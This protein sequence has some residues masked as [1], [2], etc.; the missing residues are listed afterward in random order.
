M[1]LRIALVI[2][3]TMTVSLLAAKEQQPRP[4]FRTE[5]NFVR[6]DAFPTKNG[7]PVLDLTKDDFEIIEEHA[8]QPIEQFEHVLIRAQNAQN[9]GG[10]NVRQDP[11]TVEESR[12]AVM[13]PRARVFV[14]FLDTNHVD[15]GGSWRVREPLVQALDKLIGPDDLFAV[16]TPQMSVSSLTFARKT[17]TLAG[18]L[19][20]HWNWGRQ[21][22]PME[23]TPRERDCEA[24][25]PSV[26]ALVEEAIA[27]AREQETLNA[28][29]D[30]LDYL[31]VVREER[32]A[33][34]TVTDG[35]VLYQPNP[36]L[37]S[38]AR[39][40]GADVSMLHDDRVFLDLLN[41]ANTA[42]ASFYPIDPRGLPVFDQS[43]TRPLTPGPGMQLAG[44]NNAKRPELDHADFNARRQTLQTLAG[45]TD[46]LAMINSNDLTSSFTK[47]VDD[48]SSYYLL[49]YHSTSKQDGRFHEITVR[50]K[51]PGVQV[52]ARHG[53]LAAAPHTTAAPGVAPTVPE[54]KLDAAAAAVAAAAV[55]AAVAPLN[56]YV[57][58]KPLRVQAATNGQ[59]VWVEGEGNVEINGSA[60]VTVSTTDGSLLASKYVPITEGSH[61]FMSVLTPDTP[62]SAGPY[63]IHITAGDARETMQM[64]VPP[65]PHLS[66][67]IWERRRPSNS[68]YQLAAADLR[69]RRSDLLIAKV[70]TPIGENY[71]IGTARVLDAKGNPLPIPVMPK[72]ETSD[73]FTERWF[74][75]QVVLAPLAPGD[76]IIELT[77]TNNA[78]A[79]TLAA[80]KIVP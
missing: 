38:L 61:T 19:E 26:P 21:D 73:D 32:K 78:N 54:P 59:K 29:G 39:G 47:I 51:R 20:R 2:S 41:A 31:R 68:R 49:G 44:F 75:A 71:R 58:E 24:A 42:N 66:G 79:R 27:R 77:D 55:A 80:F 36:A 64:V 3:V 17:T 12:D 53:Y 46:G 70:P 60:A 67:M 43:I 30:L 22:N 15:P 45:S 40:C 62:L 48:L 57:R 50:V 56:D 13:N 25:N 63:I 16:M 4:T 10:S 14:I 37:A 1:F 34:I 52:R 18:E 6:V 28:I 65:S 5:A 7:A 11:R 8:P 9:S 23:K 33:I 76:Y 74:S 35:W 72:I 69:F